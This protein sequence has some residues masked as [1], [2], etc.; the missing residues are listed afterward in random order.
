MIL[1]MKSQDPSLAGHTHCTSAR[2]D[3]ATS[4]DIFEIRMCQTTGYC[5]P[6]DI[7][8][9]RGG[10]FKVSPAALIPCTIIKT[11]LGIRTTRTVSRHELPPRY[12]WG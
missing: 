12:K 1:L 3:S 5:R 2:D 4:T 9:R 6:G 7:S 8:S 11:N 10:N